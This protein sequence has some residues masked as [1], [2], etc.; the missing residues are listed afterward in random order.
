MITE[1][2]KLFGF[3]S[4]HRWSGDACPGS[5]IMC[6][7]EPDEDTEESREGDAAHWV[8]EVMVKSFLERIDYSGVAAGERLLGVANP[9]NGVIVDQDMIDSAIGYHNAI[10]NVVKVKSQAVVEHRVAAKSLHEQAFGTSDFMYYDSETNTLYI[11]DF[12]YG[13]KA[14]PI[15][16]NKQLI[17]YAQAACETWG[18]T[19]LKPRL[20]L[21]LFMPRC[22]DGQGP[23]RTWNT[24]YDDIQ[25]DVGMLRM[26]C[27]QY[28]EGSTKVNS[29]PWCYKCPAGYK[30]PAI[31]EAASF[32]VDFSY[33]PVAQEP[34]NGHMAYELDV[35]YK[36][37]DRLKQRID[38]LETRAAHKIAHGELVQGYR[39]KTTYGRDAW[40]VPAKT[41]IDIGNLY[42][43]DLSKPNVALTP[44]QAA[45]ELK[46][47]GVDA[48]V[49]KPY[50]SKSQTGVK[51]VQDDGTRAKLIFS[52]EKQ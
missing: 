19:D 51:L 33:S 34:S 30:C 43:A 8:A 36:A 4:A 38:M 29:G 18:L 50:Y 22:Y 16:R 25:Y 46:K 48:A 14:L 28:E 3:S 2:S 26:A 12:K 7:D 17:G 20:S 31:R 11:F 24:S 27:Q 10:A 35:A 6:V 15:F 52:G 42:G 37:F 32:S 5:V 39:M 45:A 49:I 40:S 44:N 1:H 47:K 23:L 13:H 21:N 9:T 41:V